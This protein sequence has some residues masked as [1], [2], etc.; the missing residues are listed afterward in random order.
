MIESL[1]TVMTKQQY[2]D[3][4]N[5]VQNPKG[6]FFDFDLIPDEVKK[7]GKYEIVCSVH[8][9]KFVARNQRFLEGG[10]SCK[11]CTKKGLNTEDFIRLAK[12]THGDNRF[13]YSEAVFTGGTK[14]VKLRCIKHD[15]EFE[16][17]ALAHMNGKIG[18]VPCLGRSENYTPE[19]FIEKAFS[20]H[21]DKFDYS[22]V[23]HIKGIHTVVAITCKEHDVRFELPA[24]TH[25]NTGAHGCYMC[26]H[27]HK[28]LNNEVFL[29]RAKNA[30]PD[31]KYDYS[32]VDLKGIFKKVEIICLKEGHG[33]F[34]QTPDGHLVGKEGCPSCDKIQ[35]TAT[36]EDFI[37]RSE[38]MFPGKLTYEKT[39]LNN[40]LM[41]RVTLTCVEH[42]DYE[43]PIHT[44]LRMGYLGC[45]PCNPWGK[46]KG[47]MEVADFIRSLG[48]EVEQ[49]DRRVICPKEVDILVPSHNLA[50]EF[51]GVYWHSSRF[52][53]PA[54][55]V[56]KRRALEAA[57]YRLLVVWED[58]WMKRRDVVER[59]IRHVLG[60]SVE[61]RVFARNTV[62]GEVSAAVAREFLDRFHIQGF[63][64]AT[65]YF[66]LFRKYSANPL[67]AYP[68]DTDGGSEVPVAVMSLLREG[69]TVKLLRYA[70]SCSVV[71]GHSKLL[72]FVEGSE[73]CE[74]ASEIVTFADLAFSDGGLYMRTGW[75]RDREIPPDY[76]Y[77]FGNERRHKF[78]FRKSRFER[79]ED[80][81]FV[82]GLSESELAELN[83][84]P[85][86]YDYGKL[87]F[88]RRLGE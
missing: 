39:V 23:T 24:W 72:S 29:H 50:V 14:K 11:F 75:E 66:G 83:D 20:I 45:K 15:R 34:F 71:G 82:E 80:L 33:S 77:A 6:R 81:A 5:A 1:P 35:R 22:E 28:V 42:G 7:S 37:A 58:D 73:I 65:K 64:P 68:A 60:K 87:R 48:V 43:I 41:G 53:K 88:V 74:N 56:E 62:V 55:H 59:H 30:H 19:T 3:A 67:T 85:R 51:N 4:V 32:K 44:H 10:T 36:V 76:C 61:P 86:L 2:I 17:Q 16:Q 70:S 57:G 69:D 79:D 38:K 21:G 54:N 47:E 18:C 31:K 26:D 9:Y 52:L 27:S 25:I 46:S 8:D 63:V 78:S 84:I 49:N 40:G 12:D 13:D